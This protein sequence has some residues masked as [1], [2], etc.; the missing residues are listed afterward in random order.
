[1]SGTSPDPTAPRTGGPLFTI[2][3]GTPADAAAIHAVHR[4]SILAVGREYYTQAEVES[5]ALGLVTEHYAKVMAERRETFL[6]A[7]DRAGAVVGFC[8]SRDDEILGFYVDP[9][10]A[11]RGAG[12]ALLRH[13]ECAFLAEGHRRIWLQASRAGQSF[14]EAR[15]YE[16]VEEYPW[17]SRGGLEI[18][19]KR[20]E[21][22]LA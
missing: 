2:R 21:K 9:D 7:I 17:K 12:S 22:T 11:G 3:A 16:A 14:Y 10:F 1:M 5:W 18:M 8:S 15:G 13:A 4:R 6:V 20:M 19:V